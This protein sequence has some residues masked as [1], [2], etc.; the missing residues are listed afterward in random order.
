MGDSSRAAP[1]TLAELHGLSATARAE[2]WHEFRGWLFDS[3]VPTHAFEWPYRGLSV[4]RERVHSWP[5]CALE[6]P[7]LV[8][9]LLHCYGWDTNLRRGQPKTG[10]EESRMLWRGLV[11]EIVIHVQRIGARCNSGHTDARTVHPVYEDVPEPPPLPHEPRSPA[12]PASRS[13]T[14]HWWRAGEHEG[15]GVA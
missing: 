2:Y 5:E 15:S 7:E 1:H 3:F 11:Q 9:R 10:R 4:G 12:R 6:H 8:D 13:R 14:G